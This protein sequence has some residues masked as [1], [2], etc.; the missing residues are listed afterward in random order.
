MT[1][2]LEYK[3][4][5]NYLL[6]NIP[7]VGFAEKEI[8]N[9]DVF[10]MTKELNEVIINFVGLELRCDICKSIFFSKSLLHKHIKL[11][12]ADWNQANATLTPPCIPPLVIKFTASSKAIGSRYAFRGW[13]YAIVT[14]CFAPGEILLHT[15]MTSLYCLDTGCD[16]TFVDCNWLLKRALIEKILEIATPLKIKDIGSLKH[17][18]NEFVFIYLYFPGINLKNYSIYTQIYQELHLVKGQKAN[19]LVDNNILAT[20]KVIID[21][22][23]KTA[24]IASCQVT[25]VVTMRSKDHQMQKKVLVDRALTI[26]PKSEALV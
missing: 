25:I 4:G 11:S 3:G 15:N 12:Y 7:D 1:E 21:L 2:E 6:D 23:S 8:D 17:K 10:Y 19:L 13:N 22:I 14:V 24:I 16:I 20:K 26:P 5:G 9:G 18:L